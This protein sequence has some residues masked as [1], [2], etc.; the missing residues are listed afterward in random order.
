MKGSEKQIL[1]IVRELIE[2]DSE[3]IARKVGVSA[4]YIVEIC[5]GL[6][7]DGYLLESSNGR[8]KLLPQALKAISPTRSRGPILVLKGGG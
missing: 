7:K 6:V 4:E 1:S 2:V 3:A 5:Q 8:Y